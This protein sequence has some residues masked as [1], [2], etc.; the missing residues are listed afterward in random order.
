[1][2]SIEEK[3]D[4]IARALHRVNEALQLVIA[5]S[6]NVRDVKKTVEEIAERVNEVE[7]DVQVLAEKLTTH[8]ADE[9]KTLD[10]VAEA[11]IKRAQQ[12]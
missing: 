3:L 9:Q 12:T 4:D 5:N 2:A 10:A 11:L 1:M 7:R 8:A 6:A